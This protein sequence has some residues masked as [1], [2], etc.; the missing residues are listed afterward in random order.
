M[1]SAF[2]GEKMSNSGEQTFSTTGGDGDSSDELA[3]AIGKVKRYTL[4]L[5][6]IM[7]ITAYIDRVN[8]GF[9]RT[10][11]E[12]DVGIGAAA[13]GFGAGLFFVA[14]AIF[15]VPANLVLQKVGA[16][17]WMTRIMLTWGL[18][19]MSM[20]FVQGPISFY[21][22]RFLLGVAEAGFFPGVIYFMT[23]WLP[24]SNRGK[25]MAI[26]L[27]G[28]ALASV[29]AGPVT[30]ALLHIRGLG[31]EGWQWMFL[32]EGSFA[33]F[34]CPIA[35]YLLPNSKR[36]VRWLNQ[37]EGSAL[38]A[39]IDQEHAEK[40]KEKS[41]MSV[42]KLLLDPQ[43]ILF[44]FIYFCISATIY[45]VTFWLPSIIRGF[46]VENDI[47][48][49]FLNSVPWLISILFMYVFA[50][51]AA[52]YK[53]QQAWV[54]TAFVISGI[55]LIIAGQVSAFIAYLALCLA[56][57]GFKSASSL[58]WPIPQRY[59]DPR[60]A[61]GV[62]ALVNSIG[63]LGGFVAP[64]VFGI[65]QETTGSVS[66]GLVGLGFVALTAGALIFLTPKMEKRYQEKEVL[67]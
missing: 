41:H 65:L 61:A 2:K 8:I 5:F 18:V 39:A 27:S 42:W 53:W 55:G 58:F 44:C 60:I 30:G 54:C 1:T 37:A 36:E 11:L 3:A 6:V 21:I 23:Q 19:S 7:F 51:L 49:G 34:L 25:A 43:V 15:E 38:K 9:V 50:T 52:R 45:G 26:F 4:P 62:I 14:Y 24:H 59:L 28:S 33:L 20:A 47:Y 63:G 17:F 31:L 10:Y 67:N 16:R 29:L 48:V 35:L 57:V 22:V 56:A 66:G 40:S 12:V 32:I 64:T 46:G 13:F